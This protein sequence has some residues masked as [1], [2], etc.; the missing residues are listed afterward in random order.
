MV[1]PYPPNADQRPVGLINYYVSM[2]PS[3][4]H[5]GG[6]NVAMADGSVRFIKDTIDSWEIN[7]AIRP[8][9]PRAAR[10]DGA[11]RTFSF[12]PGLRVGVWQALSTRNVGEAISADQY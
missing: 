3:S 11:T 9:E 6:I 8:S 2:N 7:A 10:Y 4:L 5:P 12:A 1:E